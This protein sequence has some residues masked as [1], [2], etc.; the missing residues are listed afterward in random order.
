MRQVTAVWYNYVN[1]AKTGPNTRWR[2]IAITVECH[3]GPCLPPFYVPTFHHPPSPIRVI[4]PQLLKRHPSP[5]QW[6]M[7]YSRN[8]T[9]ECTRIS[10][11]LTPSSSDH[12]CRSC[13]PD[14]CSAKSPFS[15]WF[16]I[17]PHLAN[18]LAMTKHKVII[19]V[20]KC[21]EII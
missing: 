14:H 10:S 13:R 17:F 12:G 4:S 9:M 16:Y 3:K 18:N 8:N 15:T 11:V 6:R 2:S 1:I 7:Q 5:G 20:R 19:C 21:H